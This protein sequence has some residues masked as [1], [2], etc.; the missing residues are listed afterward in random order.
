MLDRLTGRILHID[1]GDCFEVAMTR[2]KFPEK[3]P[4]RLTRMLTNAMEVHTITSSHTITP[5]YMHIL[6][7]SPHTS[8]STTLCSHTH[9]L[10]TH[11]I[12]YHALLPHSSPHHTPHPLPRSALTLI[13]SPHTSS[14]TTLCSHT[15]PLTTHL[16][17]YHALL[18]LISTPHTPHTH[19]HNPSPPHPLPRSALTLIPTP[20][21][22]HTHAHD[23]S[24]HPPH[25][26]TSLLL[27]VHPCNGT[28]TSFHPSS[29]HIGDWD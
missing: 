9:P 15:H 7:P 10:T 28:Y 23:P 8:S 12:L 4:F 27:N 5:H 11:L 17:L 1:F 6:I 21:T 18:P 16:I 22:P 3:I 25:T 19:A 24:P 2:E 26:H 13:P 14:S 20:H 29:S